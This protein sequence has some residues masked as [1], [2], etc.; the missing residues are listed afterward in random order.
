MLLRLHLRVFRKV[1]S[2]L[3]KN[4]SLSKLATA[5]MTT[6]RF[7][8]F[9]ALVNRGYTIGCGPMMSRTHYV[10]KGLWGLTK[11]LS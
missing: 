5:T 7:S 10:A 9:T 11:Q 3:G 8:L 4:T 2:M 6:V 1:N